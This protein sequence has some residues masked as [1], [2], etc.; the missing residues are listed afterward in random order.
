M[1][2]G[3]TK[4]EIGEFVILDQGCTGTR[5]QNAKVYKVRSNKKVMKRFFHG[6]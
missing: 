1:I 5:G 6:R 2:R 3:Y 4:C